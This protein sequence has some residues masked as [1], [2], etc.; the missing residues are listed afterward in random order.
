M[1]KANMKGKISTLAIIAVLVF[2]I[3]EAN[4]IFALEF[5]SSSED[6][7]DGIGNNSMSIRSIIDHAES[8]LNYADDFLPAYDSEN[9][10]SVKE[11]SQSYI[12]NFRLRQKYVASFRLLTLERHSDDRSDNE[13]ILGR[14]T[15]GFIRPYYHIEDDIRVIGNFDLRLESE[16]MGI[17]SEILLTIGYDLQKHIESGSPGLKVGLSYCA[18]KLKFPLI[19]QPAKRKL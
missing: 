16:A 2:S 19:S 7:V 5:S 13:F 11:S 6:G 15:I 1:S 4:K 14:A 17:T 8:A 9:P 12:E 10:L 18:F 3:V